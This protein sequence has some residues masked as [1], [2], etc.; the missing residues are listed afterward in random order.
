[1]RRI[2]GILSRLARPFQFLFAALSTTYPMLVV[3]S[4][5][6]SNDTAGCEEQRPEVARTFQRAKRCAIASVLVI[7]LIAICSST[8]T[9]AQSLNDSPL[10]LRPGILVDLKGQRIILPAVD[11]GI[12]AISYLTGTQSWASERA[13]KP[14][15]LVDGVLLAQV[16]VGQSPILK[17][18]FIDPATGEIE[19]EREVRLPE[20]VVPVVGASK[21]MRFFIKAHR[22]EGRLILEWKHIMNPRFRAF[23]PDFYSEPYSRGLKPLIQTGQV[24]VQTGSRNLRVVDEADVQVLG[25][26][27]VPPDSASRSVGNGIRRSWGCVGSTLVSAEET[28]SGG[29]RQVVVRRWDRR[30]G[31]SLGSVTLEHRGGEFKNPSIDGLHVLTSSPDF[32]E[33]TKTYSLWAHSA[34]SGRLVGRV[35]HHVSAARFFVAGSL[36]VLEAPP[37]GEQVG[38]EWREA[39]LRLKAFELSSG[40]L[41]W[42]HVIRDTDAPV[43]SRSTIEQ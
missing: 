6:N 33:E 19:G 24:E 41:V 39:P 5:F 23:D 15:V 12:E 37:S 18:A 8:E 22:I 21:R 4:P 1:L 17:I 29:S 20:M 14:I 31:S 2:C 25:S 13:D 32:E 36:L 42:E 30:S 38:G 11:G 28:G 35:K 43:R 26:D 27:C 9:Q 34:E 10:A 40:N 16:G 3:A 7:G